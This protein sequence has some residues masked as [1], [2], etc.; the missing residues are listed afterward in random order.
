MNSAMI[1]VALSLKLSNPHA[2]A[3]PQSNNVEV[4]VFSTGTTVVADQ[5][6]RGEVAANVQADVVEGGQR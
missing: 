6:A 3:L 4:I 1:A 5:R 2:A